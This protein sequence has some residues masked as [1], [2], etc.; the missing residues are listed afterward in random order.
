[1]ISNILRSV[2]N[3]NKKLLLA[4]VEKSEIQLAKKNCM[5]NSFFVLYPI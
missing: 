3:K 4:T 5:D 1:M 2:S